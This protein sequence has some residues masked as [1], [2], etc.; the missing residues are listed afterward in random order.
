MTT[1]QRYYLETNALFKFY[2]D[3]PGALHVRQL[4]AQCTSP[5][6]VSSLTLLE[7]I[8]VLMKYHRKRQ[9]KRREVNAIARRLR[10]DSGVGKTTRRFQ[11]IQMP[12]TC[13]R[14]AEGILLQHGRHDVQTNDALHLAVV[15]KLNTADQIKL[16]TS[17][18]SLQHVARQRGIGCYDP[19]VGPP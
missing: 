19:E 12:E 18:K 4:V 14:E 16:V 8:G 9:I 10:R 7:F 15:V 2:R 11:V 3:E 5:A 17:D 13:Y 6:L 1:D